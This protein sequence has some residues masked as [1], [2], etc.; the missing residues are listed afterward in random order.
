VDVHEA[1]LHDRQGKKEADQQRIKAGHEKKGITEFP[2]VV[3]NVENQA[4]EEHENNAHQQI[5]DLQ[6]LPGNPGL[7]IGQ[8]EIDDPPGKGPQSDHAQDQRQD[9]GFERPLEDKDVIKNGADFQDPADI[10]L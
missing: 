4:D 5:K 7:A 6:A 10:H 3:G 8:D 9:M 1:I 2:D